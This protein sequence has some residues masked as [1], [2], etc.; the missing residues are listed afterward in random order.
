MRD[1]TKYEIWN[2]GIEICTLIYGLTNSFPVE[3][4][5]GLISQLRRASVSISSN[6]AEG[7]SRTSEKDFKRFIE[8]ALG[9]CFEVRTQLEIAV[10]LKFIHTDSL[11]VL[12][13]RLEK[14]SKQLNSLR[15]KIK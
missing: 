9:S 15:N 7:C 2:D 8:I 3:E 12:M 4:K 14:T 10:K 1:Y 13:S 5:F 6:F 11:E